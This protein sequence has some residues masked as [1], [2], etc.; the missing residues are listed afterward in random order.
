MLLLGIMVSKLIKIKIDLPSVKVDLNRIFVHSI[1]TIVYHTISNRRLILDMLSLTLMIGSFFLKSHTTQ[2]KPNVEAKM[3]WTCLF[4]DTQE[5]SSGGWK[6]TTIS[7]NCKGIQLSRNC[8]TLLVQCFSS[9]WSSFIS[10]ISKSY[11][12]LY[13]NTFHHFFPWYE[14]KIASIFTQCI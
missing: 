3:C 10:F 7:I 6:K 8:I 11:H 9:E 5:T 4:H 1:K 12:D 14:W 2:R 13:G